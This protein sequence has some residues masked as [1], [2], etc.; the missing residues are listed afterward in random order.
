[1]RKA[2]YFQVRYKVGEYE[3]VAHERG[4]RNLL[5]LVGEC[6]ADKSLSLIEIRPLADADVPDYVRRELR[7]VAE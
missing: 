4:R 6:L 1:M 3:H 2:Q 7:E 5:H